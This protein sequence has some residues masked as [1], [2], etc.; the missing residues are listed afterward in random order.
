MISLDAYTDLRLASKPL[1]RD[2]FF[3]LAGIWADNTAADMALS[4]RDIGTRLTSDADNWDGL[5][6][7]PIANFWSP[8][9]SSQGEDLTTSKTLGR[10][11]TIPLFVP[12]SQPALLEGLEAHLYSRQ[13]MVVG[14]KAA[15]HPTDTRYF[16]G[17]VHQQPPNRSRRGT[18][19]TTRLPVYCKSHWGFL[20]EPHTQTEADVFTPSGYPD[21]LWA[22]ELTNITSGTASITI[23]PQGVVPTSLDGLAVVKQAA[24]MTLTWSGS[25]PARM[26]VVPSPPF[27]TFRGYASETALD[28]SSFSRSGALP[29]YLQPGQSYSVAASNATASIVWLK[30]HPRPA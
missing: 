11:F 28:S 18:N 10:T 9:I 21:V 13:P 7:P 25:R 14:F 20:V 22:V 12:T 23:T 24:T 16:I 8:G 26:L 4:T 3:N 6:G 2:H 5:D 19:P 29:N 1:L 27:R 30:N 15:A 17:V